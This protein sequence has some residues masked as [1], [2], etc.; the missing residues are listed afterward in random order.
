[1]MY[2]AVRGEGRK[3]PCLFVRLS[4]VLHQPVMLVVIA[5]IP[6]PGNEVSATEAYY[7]GVCDD[8]NEEGYI[9]M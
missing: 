9:A 1:M 6:M 3:R 2:E 8:G 7:G 4:S 5:A